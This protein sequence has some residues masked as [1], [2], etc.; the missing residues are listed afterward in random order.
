M[1][2]ALLANINVKPK[3]NKEKPHICP[4]C[5]TGFTRE[6]TLGTH[7]CEKKRRHLAKNEKHVVLGY[8][9]FR[10]FYELMQKS[11]KTYDDFC[12]SQFFN[13]FVKFGSYLSNVKPLYPQK[14]IDYVITSGEKLDRW[15]RDELYYKYVLDLIRRENSETALERSINTMLDWAD[16]TGNS[17]NEYF[18]K[19]SSSRAVQDIKDGK[20]SPWLILNCKSGQNMLRS[21]TD[22]QLSIISDTI[23]V[24]FWTRRFKTYSL[25]VEL[26]RDVVKES[27][28]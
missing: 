17:W 3:S 13:S 20:M 15:C 9:A 8:D 24:S 16:R 10:R 19:V 21:F 1:S 22:E 25:D 18:S 6:T 28:L 23:E 5:G 27:G 2:K 14:Y 4:Y 12:D 7:V 11:T 26:V